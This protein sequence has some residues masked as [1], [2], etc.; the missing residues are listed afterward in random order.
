M[1]RE[2]AAPHEVAIE[3]RELP[4]GTVTFVFSDIEGSTERWERDR[5]AMQLALRRHDAILRR[6]IEARG[7]YIFKTIG[8]AFCAA[9]RTAPEAVAAAYATETALLAEDWGG[10]GDLKVRMAIH[11]GEAD[12]RDGDY[13]GPAVN[14]TARLLAIGHGTQVLVSGIAADLAQGML[15]PRVTL[16]DLGQHRLRDL[17]R[18]EWVYQLVADDLP[19]DF[20]ALRSLDALPNNLPRQLTTFVGREADV[21]EIEALLMRTQLLSIV[22]TGGVGKTRTAVQVGA[23]LLDG[24]G[25]GV[26]FVEFAPLLDASLVP[27][28]IASTLGIREAP[29][30]PLLDTIVAYLKEKRS[31][32]ILDNCEHVVAEA[33]KAAGAILRGCPNVTILVTTREGLGIAGETIYRM[34]SLAT[35]ARSEKISAEEA[36][37]YG[38]VALFEARARASDTRFAFTDENAP[39]V[40][41]ICRRLDG[42]PLAI[43]L[44][45]ARVK[46]L[47]VK[48]LADKL[49]ERFRL[50]T[51][52]DRTALPRQQTMRALVDWSYDLLSEQERLLFR[53]L[54]VF[55]GGFTLESAV[56]VCADEKIAEYE[57]LDLLSSLVDKSLV[58]AELSADDTRY[59]LLESTR[60]YAREKLTER[61]EL[62]LMAQA[63][64]RAYVSL[65]EHFAESWAT[66]PDR[67]WFDLAETELDNWRAALSW[68][69]GERGDIAAGQ[70]IAGNLRFVWHAFAAA[71]GQRWSRLGL[72]LSDETTPLEV[73]VLLELTDATLSGT[74]SKFRDAYASAERALALSLETGSDLDVARAKRIMAHS[75]AFAERAAESEPLVQ[76]AL[77]TFR[78]LGHRRETGISLRT[79]GVVRDFEG[80]FEGARSAYYEALAIFKTL[81]SDRDIGMIANHLGE[82]EF[83]AGNVEKAVEMVSQSISL[84][85]SS[86]RGRPA[87]TDLANLA[88]YLITL[89]RFD[90]ARTHARDSLS[91]AR[92]HQ[93]EVTVAFAVQHL[94]ALAIALEPGEEYSVEGFARAARLLGFTDSRLVRLGAFREFTEE[95]L[96]QALRA[97]LRNA[98][99]DEELEQQLATGGMLS[100][101]SAVAEA[102]SM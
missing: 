63:H 61:G 52:G 91:I 80:D 3:R 95:S 67:A 66:T 81:G 94:A 44:A 97:K 68:S 49:D 88:A 53:R 47:S 24:F 25:D 59:R 27:S 101:D 31:M 4:S 72:E 69:L 87:S 48:A 98:L 40:A 100:E 86:R 62:E 65:A 82:T 33:A 20:P 29:P 57:V 92:L 17:A 56:A 76:S 64:A 73:T 99:G 39:V 79:L 8:D 102:L 90:E 54:A 30:R 89:E 5:E 18:P 46:V 9:F 71:E 16:R 83:H 41:E 84:D 14:R 78:R 28:A 42:I 60:Q 74:L 15:P 37:T 75:F 2:Q 10:V 21:A 58:H 26:W 6:E 45:A 35:P 50:L 12:E 22:G 19:A 13:F 55:A 43:E 1:E 11:T 70:K 23:D 7:G 77:E 85:S 34:P 96:A 51:G 36:L 32:L 93:A 38:A